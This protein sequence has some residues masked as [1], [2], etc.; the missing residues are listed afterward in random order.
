VALNGGNCAQS[1]YDIESG[2]GE[3]I[4]SHED[5][6]GHDDHKGHGHHDDHKD[7]DEH[8][9]HK[10]HDHAEH[11]EE[12][13]SD[14]HVSY[15]LTCDNAS[16]VSGFTVTGFDSFGGLEEVDVD[17]VTANHQGSS[18]VDAKQSSVSIEH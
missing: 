11:S 18:D 13:H 1:S 2:L 9:D 14:F 17:W 15:V 4:A 6:E 8:D 7:H 10:G 3:Q 16:A 5:H 12:V